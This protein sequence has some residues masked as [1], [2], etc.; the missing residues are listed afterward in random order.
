MES[1]GEVWICCFFIVFGFST[2]SVWHPEPSCFVAFTHS[3]VSDFNVETVARWFDQI[4]SEF[5]SQGC[6][7]APLGCL[8]ETI[9]FQLQINVSTK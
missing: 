6:H 8:M 2:S 1:S 9:N 4:R 5:R 7:A 3:E